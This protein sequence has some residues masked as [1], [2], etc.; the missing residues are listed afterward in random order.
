AWSLANFYNIKFKGARVLPTLGDEV[1]DLKPFMKASMVTKSDYA[2]LIDWTDI[3]SAA[4][5]YHLQSKGLVLASAAKPF[6]ISSVQGKEIDFGYGTILLPVA[7]QKE[8]SDKIFELIK[9]VEQKFNINIHSVT[10]GY[11]ANG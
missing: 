4:A 3:N 5:L 2:Y 11:S 1:V 8:S 9:E 10:T 6:S 7:K